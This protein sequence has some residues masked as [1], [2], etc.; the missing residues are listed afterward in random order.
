[1]I[2]SGTTWYRPNEAQWA[3]ADL[4]HGPWTVHGNPCIGDRSG[5]TFD[6]QFTAVFELADR[7]GC[8]IGMAD[9]WNVEDIEAS[10]YVWLPLQ[11]EDGFLI[12]KWFDEWELS[13][14]DNA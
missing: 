5:T 1:M 4:I 12:V 14:F 9:R 7:P 6:A 10:T 8:F 2:T 3:S 13:W 11:I